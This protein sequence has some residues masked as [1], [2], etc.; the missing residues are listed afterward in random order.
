MTTKVITFYKIKNTYKTKYLVIELYRKKIMTKSSLLHPDSNDQ[1]H[2]NKKQLDKEHSFP[3]G[4]MELVASGINIF[5]NNGFT[6][7]SP[8]NNQKNSLSLHLASP[9][10]V[11]LGA[12]TL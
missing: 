3:S 6:S 7:V 11:K 4:T 12:S 2:L 9:L 8:S 5:K 1:K 10:S